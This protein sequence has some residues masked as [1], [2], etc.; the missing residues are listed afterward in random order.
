MTYVM[1]SLYDVLDIK[2]DSNICIWL[3]SLNMRFCKDT[4]G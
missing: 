1:R 4:E 2:K 3:M